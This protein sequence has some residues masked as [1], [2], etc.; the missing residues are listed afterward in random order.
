MLPL[1]ES[2]HTEFKTSFNEE[3]TV[4]L[5]AF[6]NAKGGKVYVGV[7]DKGKPVG[8]E[9]EPESLQKWINEIKHK[10]EPSIIP[11]ADIEEIEGK[12]VVVLSVQEYPI[13]PVSVKGRYYKRQANSNHQLSA[14]EIA[15][16]HLQTV[17][18]SWDFYPSHNKG[19][20]DIDFDKEVSS[21][22]RIKIQEIEDA[23]NEILA[24]INN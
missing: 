3:V 11:D 18:S 10:T 5:V 13:K 20:D 21:I 12:Q 22:G 24:T 19:L 9:L 17:N 6:A 15:D 16:M 4:S 8:V 1:K 14:G 7:N 23:Q 2:L